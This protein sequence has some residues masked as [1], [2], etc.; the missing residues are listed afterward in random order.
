MEMGKRAARVKYQPRL[1]T[2]VSD[3][4]VLPREVGTRERRL[5]GTA[6]KVKETVF[7]RQDRESAKDRKPERVLSETPFALSGFR[8]FAICSCQ[9]LLFDSG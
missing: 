4:R 6:I 1:W 9:R 7:V 2:N 5:K 8:A 3:E